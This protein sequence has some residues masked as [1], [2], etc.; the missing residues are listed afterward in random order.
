MIH[1]LL[2]LIF[3]PIVT[4]LIARKKNPKRL[5]FYTGLSIGLVAAPFCM[6][7]YGLYYLHFVSKITAVFYVAM[8]GFVLMVVHWYPAGLIMRAIPIDN[9]RESFAMFYILQSCINAFVW[10]S[11]Y[12]FI[13]KFIDKKRQRT[14]SE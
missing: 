14:N 13:G 6:G 10:M 12:G 11:F 2:S 4:F 8:A 3:V 5:F 1:L 9:L 7:I